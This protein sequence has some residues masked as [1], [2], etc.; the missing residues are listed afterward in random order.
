MS[1]RVGLFSVLSVTFVLIISGDYL[2]FSI[3]F[4]FF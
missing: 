1:V 4:F 2:G 3:L